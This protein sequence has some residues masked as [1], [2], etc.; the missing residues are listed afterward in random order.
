MKS[1]H[2]WPLWNSIWSTPSFFEH[3]ARK[4]QFIAELNFDQFAGD[5][6]DEYAATLVST[7]LQPLKFRAISQAMQIVF[8]E[9]PSNV[10]RWIVISK[11]LSI[12]NVITSNFYQ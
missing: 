3:F 2:Q 9:Y 12:T 5:A 1:C 11:D 8:D 7:N 10:I 6:F 4:A